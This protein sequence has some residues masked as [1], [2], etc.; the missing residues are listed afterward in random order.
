MPT[1]KEIQE[2]IEPRLTELA[3]EASM[4]WH[5]PP[6]HETFNSEGAARAAISAAA[7]VA[8]LVT[9]RLAH[10]AAL[11]AGTVPAGEPVRCRYCHR[12]VP[13]HRA[14][15]WGSDQFVCDSRR[16]CYETM[17]A[18]DAARSPS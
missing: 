3:G 12:N 13:R 4:C 17:D 14:V 7:D 8:E 15:P 6:S 10:E 1:A 5:P 2:F 16:E 18:A 11:A 9:R